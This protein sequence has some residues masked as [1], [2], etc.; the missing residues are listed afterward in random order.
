MRQ[1]CIIKKINFY[2]KHNFRLL[3]NNSVKYYEEQIS[4]YNFYVEFSLHESAIY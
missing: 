3:Q 4:N 1:T 2:Q